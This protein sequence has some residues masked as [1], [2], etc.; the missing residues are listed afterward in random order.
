[1][2]LSE[3]EELLLVSVLADRE[4]LRTLHPLRW[5]PGED[6]FEWARLNSLVTDARNGIVRLDWFAWRGGHCGIAERQQNSRAVRRLADLELIV[7]HTSR[8][9]DRQT[10]AVEL[11]KSGETVAREIQ[12]ILN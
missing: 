6:R 8:F 7:R 5:W 4:R 9:G 1:M 3:I 2:K 11:T 12:H 10:K